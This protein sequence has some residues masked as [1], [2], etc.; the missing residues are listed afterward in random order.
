MNEEKKLDDQ[1]TGEASDHM[2]ARWYRP[3]EIILGDKAYDSKVDVWSTGYIIAE[4][5]QIV[6]KSNNDRILYKGN[7]CFS[8]YPIV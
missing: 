4:L 8:N 5:V 7:S 6:Y 1:N 2:V 3:P